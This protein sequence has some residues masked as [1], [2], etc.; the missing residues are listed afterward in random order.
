M[1][2]VPAQLPPVAAGRWSRSDDA[3]LTRL[4][5]ALAGS[6]PPAAAQ[7]AAGEPAMGNAH[8]KSH[9]KGGKAHDRD[10]H[11]H[12]DSAGSGLKKGAAEKK[13]E[14]HLSDHEGEVNGYLRS[15]EKSE[16]S[17]AEEISKS[18]GEGSQSAG[19]GTST[20]LPPTAAKLKSEGN[21]FFKGGQFGEAVLKYSEAIEYV[22]GLGECNTLY[23]K[24]RTV[25]MI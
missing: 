19:G 3:A 18:H 20:S 2:G 8:R 16:S 22:T 15:D 24:S 4:I 11:K 12:K 5:N 6:A 23:F 9:G 21:E 17:E 14:K 1:P 25:L 13:S 7:A 10:T